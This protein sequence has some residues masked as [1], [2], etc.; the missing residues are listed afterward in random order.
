MLCTSNPRCQS[1]ELE[2]HRNSYSSS[3]LFLTPSLHERPYSATNHTAT[4]DITKRTAEIVL[5]QPTPILSMTGKHAA[6][7][8]AAKL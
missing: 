8:A 1:L 3:V 4:A 5:N 2:L 7:P 6:V